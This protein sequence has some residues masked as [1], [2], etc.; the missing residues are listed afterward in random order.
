[1]KCLSHA[2]NSS[3]GQ[4]SICEPK[5]IHGSRELPN[6]TI[7]SPGLPHEILCYQENMT[8][9]THLSEAI[10]S[11][12]QTHETTT[13]PQNHNDEGAPSTLGTQKSTPGQGSE[14]L[15]S[16]EEDVTVNSVHYTTPQ[17][18]RDY[19]RGEYISHSEQDKKN[20]EMELDSIFF[21]SPVVSSSR[22]PDNDNIR[23]TSSE[24]EVHTL[25][26]EVAL[27]KRST[28]L[29]PKDM[30]HSEQYA[31][32]IEPT[33]D[34]PFLKPASISALKVFGIHN[35]IPDNDNNFPTSSEDEMHVK[36]A[37]YATPETLMG[38][39]PDGM[40]W[41]EHDTRSEGSDSD[42]SVFH[43]PQKRTPEAFCESKHV[44]TD[45]TKKSD[46]QYTKSGHR[47][48]AGYE[49]LRALEPIMPPCSLQVMFLFPRLR[50]AERNIRRKR[51]MHITSEIK[52]H[53]GSFM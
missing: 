39:C 45:T 35:I 5:L 34:I 14:L 3:I 41:S 16:S 19:T 43:P 2:A 23:S 29:S 7:A 32:D 4:D 22:N 40:L 24:F 26:K 20:N 36:S 48:R 11:E 53:D 33:S 1:V 21:K 10:Q 18:F 38:S 52:E 42:L 30:P 49:T 46:V 25:L 12:Q 37:D 17:R 6:H 15:D 8:A 27:P 51:R 9:E 13:T 50:A 44:I 47:I 31:H 28:D